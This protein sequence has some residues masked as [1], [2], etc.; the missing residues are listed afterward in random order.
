MKGKVKEI[1]DGDTFRVTPGW[2]FNSESGDIVRP[3][4]YNA[5]EKAERG[6]ETAKKKLADLILHKEVEL[7]NAIKTTYGRLLCDVYFN[8]KYLADYFP[9][10]K[11]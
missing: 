2:R 4:G 7:R 11:C 5:P 8:G 3:T 1:I 6:Y 9:E 10:Y